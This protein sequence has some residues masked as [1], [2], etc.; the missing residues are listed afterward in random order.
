MPY[1]NSAY[2]LKTMNEHGEL[3][4]K[5]TL[6]QKMLKVRPE[7]VNSVEQALSRKYNTMSDF[8]DIS[9]VLYQ[10]GFIIDEYVDEPQ[11]VDYIFN[12]EIYGSN[13]LELTIIPTNAC[14][15][16]CIYCYQS[17]PYYYM[18]CETMNNIILY[19]DKHIKDYSGLIISWFGGEPLLAKGIIIEMM[20]KIRTI[21][22]KN[23]K[24]FYSNITTNGYELDKN[25]FKALVYNHVR[26]FQITIDGPKN[27]H[28]IQR[29]HK[30]KGD[31]F[32]RIIDNLLSIKREFKKLNFKIAI[33]TNVS[34]QMQQYLESYIEWLYE[35]FGNDN[36]FVIIWEFV[37]D[38]G[39]EKIEKNRELIINNRST[40][41][42]LDILSK[43][44][45][46]IKMGYEQNDLTIALCTASKKNG[47]VINHDG[48]VY[49]CAMVVE[50]NNFKSINNI[51]EIKANGSMEL[52]IGKMVKW[53]GRDK[54]EDKCILCKHYP[55]C[56][57]ISCPLGIRILNQTN[58][59]SELFIN[60]YEYLL[61]NRDIV[62]SI[63]YIK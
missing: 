43:K 16:N 13:I 18:T 6:T 1:K 56:M 38:W 17:G 20:S 8:D 7:D 23:K 26:Y 53:L 34:S 4:L 40:N 50:D 24:P 11:I 35:N 37:R 60:D 29:P 46:T 59:C 49:K 57:G 51:G 25:T 19:I 63:E 28:N 32:D 21:C 12:C 31:S 22:L 42:W 10:N 27:I 54:P 44:G 15:F 9:M 41:K 33:R 36:H 52:D 47:F 39:G 5:N 14:N 30:S 48:K 45:F 3:I 55:E 61:R 58:R 2:I 62:K